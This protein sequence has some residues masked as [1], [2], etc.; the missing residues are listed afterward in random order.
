[1]SG[2]DRPGKARAWALP[3]VLF[4][5]VVA[6]HLVASV[7]NGFVYDDFEVLLAQASV[8]SAGDAARLFA[9]PHGLPLSGLPYYRPIPRLTLL[10]Q[11]G[12]HG[13]RPAAFHAGNALLMGGL[14]LAGFAVLR[15]RRFALPP[16]AAALGAAAFALHPLASSVAHPI[17]SG[18]ETAIPALFVLCAV[19]A[20][21]GGGG[22]RRGAALVAF[23]LALLSKEQALVTPALLLAADALRLPPDA[24]G[25]DP[26][27]WLVRHAPVAGVGLLYLLLRARV[28]AAPSGEEDPG[29]AGVVG[30]VATTWAADPLGP[31]RVLA[32][33]VQSFFAPSASLA[34]EPPFAV[35]FSPVRLVAATVLLGLC[36]A[37]T[38]GLGRRADRAPTLYW[39]LWVPI[40]AALTLRLLPQE[41][42]FAERFVFLSSLGF[43]ALAT[44]AAA[45]FAEARGAT[46]AV[47]GAGLALVAV[48]SAMTVQRG[49]PYRDGLAFARQWV[50][51][52]PVHGNARYAHGTAL[53]AAGRTAEAVA[54]L[55]EATRLEPALAS[56]HYNLGVLLAGQ[57]R[58]GEA[59]ES[60]RT[61]LALH[62]EDASA[63]FAL[64]TLLARSGRRAEAVAHLREA[65][66]LAPG[67][68][69]PARAL[70][71]LGAAP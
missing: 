13:E 52:N 42:P 66:R 9:E 45:R 53:A 48:L 21:L 4:C 38:L 2:P 17:S 15:R 33:A 37:G 24:P 63:H 47:A 62:P 5:A 3:G 23:A 19:A 35:W 27:A 16:G 39:L 41:A 28:F 54:E 68:D 60:F 1:M 59:M 10:A 40:G 12:L 49:V 22:R 20:W 34:Y 14:A 70:A 36:L 67:W 30:L 61:A 44:T 58:T 31:L 32:F 64:G 26:R 29:L 43:V 50:A 11:K 8:R 57:G 18:R 56:A 51:S 6:V 65:A 25:R 69:E 71:E 7:R 55:R 46:R